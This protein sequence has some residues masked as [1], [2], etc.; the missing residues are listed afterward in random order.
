MRD[1][2]KCCVVEDAQA[3]CVVGD[4]QVR[5]FMN[6]IAKIVIQSVKLVRYYTV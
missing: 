4:M 6:D 5:R 2:R 3:C 1:V